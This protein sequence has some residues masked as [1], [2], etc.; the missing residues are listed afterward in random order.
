MNII[1]KNHIVNVFIDTL[2][3]G[4]IQLTSECLY[5]E[6]YIMKDSRKEII[7]WSLYDWANSSFATTVMAGFFPIFFSQYWSYGADSTQSTFFLGLGNSI[8]SLVIALIAP[9]IGAIADR[10]SYRKKL[11]IFFAFLGSVMTIGL[12]FI[13]MGMWP[14]AIFFYIVATIGFSG[15]NTLYDSLLPS[16]ASEKKIDFVS[17]LGY[18]L[19]YIG[20]GLLFLIN[21]AMYIFPT[22]FGLEDGIEGVKASFITVGVW[23]MVFTIPLILFVK[24]PK[25]EKISLGVAVK[26]GFGQIGRTLKDLRNLKSIAWFLVGYW[27]YIDGV[28]TIIRMATDYGTAL[29]FSA[30][31]LIIALLITQFVAFP[32]AIGYNFLG[33]KIGIR[34]ALNIAIF[35]YIAIATLGYFMQT[36]IHFFILAMCIGLFQ[37]GIQALSRSY[38][39]RLIPKEH[40]SQFYGFFNMLGKFAAIIGPLLVGVISVITGDQRNGIFSLVILF[41]IGFFLLRKVDEDKAAEEVEAYRQLQ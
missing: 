3:R 19:G 4:K 37:G 30:T 34:K 8:A 20:G 35:A 26:D 21:V 13:A 2:L 23:W 39:A 16:V 31:S 9:I 11:L 7:S 32:A 1:P 6:G 22:A 18:G 36:E 10:G 25:G 27:C 41:I 14:M 15:A 5:S 12:A 40:S 29:G 28:D 17:S 38:Y 24:E 33:Q